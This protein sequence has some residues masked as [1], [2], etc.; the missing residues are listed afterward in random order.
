MHD[1]RRGLTPCLAAA[2][3]A[4]A[5]GPP[6]PALADDAPK[7]GERAGGAGCEPGTGAGTVA[8]AGACEFSLEG[9]ARRTRV[10]LGPAR[11]GRTHGPLPKGPDRRV[12]RVSLAQDPSPS[13]AEAPSPPAPGDQ[14]SQVPGPGTGGTGGEPED[15]AR[16]LA[17]IGGGGSAVY[18]VLGLL[19]LGVGS[20]T[21]LMAL[22]RRA[23]GGE[24]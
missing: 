18:A 12:V 22:R 5:A 17:E 16:E 3:L 8:S 1:L 4:V 14:P 24:G 19:F 15:P 2:V 20:A 6:A 11:A 23:G 9:A 10:E 13:G 21:A 7:G